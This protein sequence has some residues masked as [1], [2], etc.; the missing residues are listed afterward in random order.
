MKYVSIGLVLLA[1]TGCTVSIGSGQRHPP[2]S[3]DCCH[4]AGRC[5]ARYAGV[6]KAAATLPYG[7]R[8][9]VLMT[10]ANKGDLTPSDCD[11]LASAAQSLPYGQRAELLR[12]LAG[13]TCHAPEPVQPPAAP[14]Q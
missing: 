10:I 12:T 1:L 11:Q 4:G 13:R 9:Q 14:A 8:A 7:E 5:K 2:M 3:S 6:I